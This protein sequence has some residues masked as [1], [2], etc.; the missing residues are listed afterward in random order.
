MRKLLDQVPQ[1]FM[2]MLTRDTGKAEE[3]FPLSDPDDDANPAGKADDNRCWNEFNDAAEAAE[4][5]E[6]QDDS[7]HDGG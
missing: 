5:H 1:F 4:A 3:I 7:G 6:H 2:E